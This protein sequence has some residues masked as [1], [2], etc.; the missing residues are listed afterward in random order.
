M[1]FLFNSKQKIGNEDADIL[2]NSF[3]LFCALLSFS[4]QGQEIESLILKEK[5]EDFSKLCLHG[6]LNKNLSIREKYCYS[7][8]KLAKI[9]THYKKFDL[10]LTDSSNII[11][12]RKVYWSE[13]RLNLEILQKFDIR[14]FPFD[15]Q[16]I[17]LGLEFTYNDPK[18]LKINLM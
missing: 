8:I 7:L 1:A 5:K 2:E 3:E 13:V 12:G 14:K 6:L 18:F 16:D 9:L 15:K 4:E 17:S 10:V 11:N